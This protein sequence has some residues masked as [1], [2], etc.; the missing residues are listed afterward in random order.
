MTDIYHLLKRMLLRRHN[1]TKEKSK[2]VKETDYE[3]EK[4]IN[5]KKE[6]LRVY[7][8]KPISFIVAQAVMILFLNLILAINSEPGVSA[9]SRSEWQ[10]FAIATL[11]Y[12]FFILSIYPLYGI[13]SSFKC[14]MILK[15]NRMKPFSYTFV[16]ILLFCTYIGAVYIISNISKIMEIVI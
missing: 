5:E 12:S 7:T 13:Y 11:A 6:V 15:E 2:S 9:V 3:K 4:R 14:F 10:G 16:H 1:E 8:A